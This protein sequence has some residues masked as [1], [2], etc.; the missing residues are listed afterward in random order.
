[1]KPII[2]TVLA[3]IS[4]APAVINANVNHNAVTLPNIQ[5]L[6]STKVEAWNNC[7]AFIYENSTS[8]SRAT[9]AR[10][11]LEVHAGT[12]TWSLNPL[13]TAPTFALLTGGSLGWVDGEVIEFATE[14]DLETAANLIITATTANAH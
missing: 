10:L 3:A 4:F 7:V 11:K 13:S 1:M 12:M 2:M 8:V 14:E 5:T 6:Q 9:M